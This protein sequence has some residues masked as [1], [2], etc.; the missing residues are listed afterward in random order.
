MVRIVQLL[1]ILL[2]DFETL[3]ILLSY[4]FGLTHAVRTRLLEFLHTL[5]ECG[6]IRLTLHALLLQLYDLLQQLPDLTLLIRMQIDD[7]RQ[8][9]QQERGRSDTRRCTVDE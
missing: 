8:T 6:L 3:L 1:L 7:A 5:L 4:V 9:A 2:D